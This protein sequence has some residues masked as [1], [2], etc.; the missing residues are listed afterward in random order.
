M[1]RWEWGDSQIAGRLVFS[2]TEFAIAQMT[3]LEEVL[4]SKNKS[5]QATAKRMLLG[6]HEMDATLMQQ[7]FSHAVRNASRAEPLP[8][9]TIT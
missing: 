8:P 6:Y 4:R 3:L 1:S 7:S 5:F 2:S 9:L